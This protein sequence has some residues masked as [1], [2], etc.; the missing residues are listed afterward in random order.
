MVLYISSA[1][2][3]W[4]FG[5]KRGG[6]ASLARYEFFL[7][8]RWSRVPGC[9]AG[10]SMR[11]GWDSGGRA[12]ST[13]IGDRAAPAGGTVVDRFFYKLSFPMAR[14]EAAPPPAPPRPPRADLD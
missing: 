11:I 8:A 10:G 3:A 14:P 6:L 12:R 4:T 13:R 1:I 7:S 5:P 2:A 9:R